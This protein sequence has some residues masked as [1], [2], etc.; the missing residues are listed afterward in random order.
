MGTTVLSFMKTA[1]HFA[2]YSEAE[3]QRSDDQ[4]LFAL[5]FLVASGKQPGGDRVAGPG[6]PT[7]FE[8]DYISE[9]LQTFHL[10]E[11]GCKPEN[12]ECQVG[13]MCVVCFL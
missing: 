5:L 12:G 3:F 11:P 9:I 4:E 13:W 1:M 10:Q 6:K 7:V 8:I 2:G